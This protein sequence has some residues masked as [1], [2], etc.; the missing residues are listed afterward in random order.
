MIGIRDMDTPKFNLVEDPWI[1]VLWTEGAQSLVG[2]REAFA[3]ASE[4]ADLS[5]APHERIS[6]IRLLV[7]IAQA[8]LRAPETSYDWP[9]WG[10]DLDV[11]A[12]RYLD[13]WRDR[14]DLFCDG[15][16][17]LQVPIKA[18]GEAVAA[19]KLVPHLA[20]GN[21]PTLFD[22]SGGTDRPMAPASLALALLT[23][24]NFYPLY[25]AGYKGKG[26][27]VDSNMVHTVLGGESLKDTILLNCLDLKMIAEHFRNEGIGRPIWELDP[28]DES[29][30]VTESYLARLVP[31]HRNLRLL[32][33]GTGF[34]LV[35]Q[36]LSYPTYDAAIEP[37]AT[38]TV[39][40]RGSQ[41][42]LA[43]L[44]ARLNRSL[45]RDLHAV[46]ALRES[47]ADERR[48]PLV[49]R[50][51]LDAH[52]EGEVSLW[53]GALVTDLKAKIHDTV[54]SSFTVPHR[55]F[56]QPGQHRYERGASYAEDMSKRLYGAVRRYSSA[57]SHE[58]APTDAAQRS[59]WNALDQRS[60]L[61]LGL[62]EGIGTDADPL[63]A[64]DFGERDDTGALDPWSEA[65]A[66]AARSAY[67]A[68]CPRETPRQLQAYA[69]GLR[70]LY[71][72]PKKP[73]PAAR[74]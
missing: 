58:S 68:T 71:P 64:R 14:F 42:T 52:G 60:S 30:V 15:Q 39:R 65:V 62:L 31:R 23:F 8:A 45:W 54:E 69:A 4:I 25:G 70:V 67:E 41:E 73:A 21:N 12:H 20:S 48:G 24:Q 66:R 55:L 16:R 44:S 35:K 1:P 17:F 28:G 59:F 13:Q 53:L 63:G 2:L 47:S 40:K 34:H 37:S 36:A 50:S 27:C 38:V 43:L 19:S 26:T 51:H 10:D 56:S 61:L 7:C 3:R 57:L 22:H 33:D 32:D 29:A 72:K 49:L 46:A 18:N 5:A 9:G 6:L 74:T 11:A